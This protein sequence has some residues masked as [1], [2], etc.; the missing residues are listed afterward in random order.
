MENVKLE[1]VEFDKRFQV[2]SEDQLEARYL[3]TPAFM[4][5]L[6]DL[7][8]SF[9]TNKVKCSF[10]NNKIMFAISTNEDLFEVGNLFVPLSNSKQMTK[11]FNEMT[12]I[13]EMVDHFKLDQ[14]I[15]L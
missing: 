3:V 11:F 8:T 9:G 15:G 5:R 14:K 1:D 7:Q 2:A 6:K 12:S 10:F 4:G 13:L